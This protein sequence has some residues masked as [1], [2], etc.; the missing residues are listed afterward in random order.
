MGLLREFLEYKDKNYSIYSFIMITYAHSSV[1]ISNELLDELTQI[2]F[3]KSGEVC[4]E[5]FD[6]INS[7]RYSILKRKIS[8]ENL[9]VSALCAGNLAVGKFVNMLGDILEI[10][11]FIGVGD[12]NT[13]KVKLA[14]GIFY[15][16]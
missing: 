14:K 6:D 15:A 10:G 13:Q 9:K 8:D 4:G 7:A 1:D 5:L 16:K 12:E 3:E 2:R 11:A